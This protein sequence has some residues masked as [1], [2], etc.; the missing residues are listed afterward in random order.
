[1][2]R[3]CCIF[4]TVVLMTNQ[5][6][7]GQEKDVT[8]T[9]HPVIQLWPEGLP[10]GAKPVDAGAIEKLREQEKAD[11]EHIRYVES[12]TMSVYRATAESATGTAVIIFPGGG[13]NVLAWPKEGTEVAEWFNSIGVTAFVLKYRV[14]RRDPD[15]PQREPLQ[16]AQRAISLVRHDAK[17][18]GIDPNRIG[19]LGFSAGGHLTVAAAVETERTYAAVDAA[20]KVDL[21]PNFIC[22]IYSAYLGNH[23]RDNVAELGDWIKVKP[24]FPQTFL[25]VTWDDTMRGAQSAL[26]FAR[27]KEHNVPAELHVWSK[28][29]HGYGLRPGDDAV[30]QWPTH[31]EA[32]LRSSGLLDKP[33]SDK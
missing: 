10:E 3:F 9:N 28:G 18:Y 25:A 26:L 4:L 16:D 19:L 7:V 8:D 15:S 17:E 32:W 2:F 20:D 27:L 13:Y 6:C 12:P 23:L 14:P 24:E 5:L 11:P 22:P 31:L 33:E 1:M 29:G 21:R 30:R